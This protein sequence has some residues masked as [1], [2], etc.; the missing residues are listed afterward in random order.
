MEKF[1]T[2][3]RSPVFLYLVIIAG[4]GLLAFAIKC[5][6]DPI[7]LV[8]GGFTGISILLKQLTEIVYEGGVKCAGICNCMESHGEA[9]YR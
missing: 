1:F 7:S 3:K 2:Y 9:F 6:F 8:T 4:T 5:I